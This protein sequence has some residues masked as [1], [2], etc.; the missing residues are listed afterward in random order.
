[1][2]YRQP[3]KAVLHRK[4]NI[5]KISRFELRPCSSTTNFFYIIHRTD[6]YLN[7]GSPRLLHIHF[8]L[9]FWLRAP[10]YSLSQYSPLDVIPPPPHLHHSPGPPS[11]PPSSPAVSKPPPVHAGR[12]RRLGPLRGT[13]LMCKASG[14]LVSSLNWVMVLMWPTRVSFHTAAP[15]R[16]VVLMPGRVTDSAAEPECSR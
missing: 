7:R 5:V 11:Y 2:P 12:A 13:S 14:P 10:F 6:V 9:E 1:M 16:G 15:R 4:E 8:R 3:D